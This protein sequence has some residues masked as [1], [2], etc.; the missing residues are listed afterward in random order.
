M[1]FFFIIPIV[2]GGFGNWILPL[3]L[4]IPDIIFPRLN[5]LRFWLL[6]CSFIILVVSSMIRI[7]AGLGW[8]IYPPLS[9]IGHITHR[10]DFAIFS[11]HLAGLSSIIGSINIIT[12]VLI[13]RFGGIRLLRIRL[14]LWRILVTLILLLLSLPVLAGAITIL[15]IDRNF[16]TTFFDPVGGGDPVLFQHLFWFFGHPEVYILILPAFGLISEVITRL[17]NR[18][19]YGHIGIIYAIAS[20]GVLG[21]LVW[22]HHIFTVGLDVDTRLYFSMATIIIAVPTGIKIFNWVY[23]IYGS[24][25]ICN[26]LLLWVYGFIFLFTIGG[27]TGIVL[28]NSYLDISLHDTYYVTA[29]FHYVLRMGAVFGIFLGLIYWIPKIFGW[30]YRSSYTYYV[31]I[32]VG[33]NFTFFPQHFIGLMG[34]PRRYVK[35]RDVYLTYRKIR[36]YSLLIT[37]IGVV[38]FLYRIIDIKDKSINRPINWHTNIETS[39]Y[40]A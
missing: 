30:K 23:R 8:T 16:N 9:R 27:L 4:N 32:F 38:L 22:A 29:H 37:M 33:V 7:G 36:T 24:V 26:H 13:R 12:T 20:I 11:L 28:S 34:I 1:I 18:F 6:P 10:V 3:Y 15:L 21:F 2:I 17:T 39:V 35:Y 5:N 31:L 40:S 25:L 19:T 14:Y